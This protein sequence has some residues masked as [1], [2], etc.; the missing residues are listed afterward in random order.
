MNWKNFNWKKQISNWKNQK[1]GLWDIAMKF[2]I[3]K[4]TPHNVLIEIYSSRPNKQKYAVYNLLGTIPYQIDNNVCQIFR[5]SI[6]DD[7][8]FCARC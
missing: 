6:N 4:I 7:F 3:E 2:Q 5:I 1:V 8:Q